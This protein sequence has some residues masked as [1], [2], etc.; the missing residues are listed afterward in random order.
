MYGQN[1]SN[2]KE[3][4][5]F[6]A[7]VKVFDSDGNKFELE[8]LAPSVDILKAKI[9]SHVNLIDDDDFFAAA[10][11]MNHATRKDMR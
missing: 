1:D 8:V 11:T 6:R 4:K 9:T 7:L 5:S 10:A 3:A 2:K